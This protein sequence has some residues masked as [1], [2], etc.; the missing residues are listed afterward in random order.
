MFLGIDVGESLEREGTIRRT[1]LANPKV[2]FTHCLLHPVEYNLG[3]G[4]GANVLVRPLAKTLA[5][6][7]ALMLKRSPP[8]VVAAVPCSTLVC[9]ELVESHRLPQ[10]SGDWIGCEAFKPFVNPFSPQADGFASGYPSMAK[11]TPL[12]CTVDGICAETG[13]LGGVLNGEPSPLRHDPTSRSNSTSTA[14][15]TL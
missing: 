7:L 11:V 12:T 15:T 2:P 5:M 10:L 9:A 3:L 6:Q 4:F 13:M 1:V 14:L 8:R